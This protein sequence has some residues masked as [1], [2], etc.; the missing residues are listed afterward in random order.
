MHLCGSNRLKEAV[1]FFD[2]MVGRGI[3]ADLVTYNSLIHGFCQM[4]LWK[5]A[6]RIFDRML[7]QG[8]SPDLSRNCGKKPPSS[9][10]PLR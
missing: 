1:D 4:G 3:S 6:T 7:E 2:E 9:G 10:L 8:V 5:E